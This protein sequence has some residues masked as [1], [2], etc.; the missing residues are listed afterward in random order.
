VWH[1]APTAT[2]GKPFSGG[3]TN[4]VFRDNVFQHGKNGKCGAYNPVDSF[5]PT[6]P[7]NAFARNRWD[8]GEPLKL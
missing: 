4:I 2:G 3:A 8:S 1:S 5:D 7:G 6:R